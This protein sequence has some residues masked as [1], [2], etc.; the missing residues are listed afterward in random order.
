MTGLRGQH[1]GAHCALKRRH[2]A[3]HVIGGQYQQQGLGI[4]RGEC[5]VCGQ[6]DRRGGVAAHRFEHDRLR[7]TIDRAQLLG[8]QEAVCFIA[9][10]HRRSGR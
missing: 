10:D 5:R 1:C 7:V 8:H 9:H 3:Y 4:T 2:V 6:R